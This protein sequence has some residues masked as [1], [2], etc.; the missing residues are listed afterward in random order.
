MLALG[1]KFKLKD[2]ALRYYI[3]SFQDLLVF[4]QAL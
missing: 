4:L 3:S 2:Y 1:L